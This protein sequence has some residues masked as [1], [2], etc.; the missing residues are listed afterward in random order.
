MKYLHDK[1]IMKREFNSGDMILLFN[2]RFKL[3]PGNLKSKWSRPFKVVNV[4]PF[5]VVDLESDDGKR[6]FKVNGQ[7]IRHYLGPIEVRR[8]VSEVDLGKPP[9]TS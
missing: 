5:G 9:M 2:S 4:Y 6:I 7:R 1:K 8:M 3:F